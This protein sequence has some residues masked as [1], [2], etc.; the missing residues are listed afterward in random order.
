[1]LLSTNRKQTKESIELKNNNNNNN[2]TTSLKRIGSKMNEDMPM[3]ENENDYTTEN[4]DYNG[5][6]QQ[7][8]HTAKRGRRTTNSVQSTYAKRRRGRTQRS[9][10]IG[11]TKS[12]NKEMN[13]K[14]YENEKNSC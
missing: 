3:S 9:I 13:K 7:R 2:K 1:M 12:L 14:I 11:H 4:D 5:S 6:F 8:N 10:S